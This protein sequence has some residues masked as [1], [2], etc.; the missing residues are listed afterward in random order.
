MRLTD[1]RWLKPLRVTVSLAFF[2][3]LGFLFL[4]FAHLT[5]VWLRESLLYPQFVPSLVAFLGLAGL[6]T[7][8]FLFVLLLTLLFGRVFCSSICPLGTLQDIFIRLH[9]KIR[10]RKVRFRYVKPRNY[11]RYGVLALSAA[12]FAFGGLLLINLLDPFSAFGRIV[13][14]LA[15]PLYIGFNN[16]GA[17]LLESLDIYWLY[18]VETHFHPLAWLFPLAWLIL[19]WWT[20]ARH[21]RLYC[22]TLCPV[23]ALLGLI[24]RFA[25]FQIRIDQQAC[26]VCAHCSVECKAGCIRLKTREIDFSRCVAC[27]NCMSVCPGLGIGYRPAW[28]GKAPDPLPAS[29]PDSQRRALLLHGASWLG[30]GLAVS[31]GVLALPI[32]ENKRPTTRPIV[33][34]YPVAPPGGQSLAH[35]TSA[36]TACHLC[37][38]VCPTGVLQPAFLEYGLSGLL[39]ARMDYEHAYCTYECVA[40]TEVCPTGALR[41][42]S[43]K[44]KK[45]T[46]LGVA[47]FVKENCIVHTEK[48]ACGA[49][50]EHCPTKAVH[51]VAYEEN[52]DI[53][54]VKQEICIGCGACERVCPVGP[55]KAIYV[56]GNPRQV[57]AEKPGGDK[58]E[59]DIQEDFPF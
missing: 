3:P 21:G 55:Y 52:L 45:L 22:N 35:F 58:L 40:C 43:V 31:G 8:G 28:R 9:E 18:P 57:M 38:S 44:D 24:S 37:I 19:L 33:K 23:G 14:D 32:P 36:C 50:D 16:L 29:S 27:H 1:Q 25:L 17:D 39:Q 13:T 4:D 30:G 6:A 51:L 54:E 26:T 10:P 59:V 42:L 56:E 11:L 15:R 7:A 41:P 12:S 2:L 49:C 20:T 47:Y 5:P 34:N 48:T 46:Q 53:P